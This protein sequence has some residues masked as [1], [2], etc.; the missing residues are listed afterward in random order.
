MRALKLSSCPSNRVSSSDSASAIAVATS[1]R[2]L[3]AQCLEHVTHAGLG[4]T[5]QGD[6]VRQSLARERLEGLGEWS[7]HVEVDIPVGPNDEQRQLGDVLQQQERRVVGPVQVVDQQDLRRHARAPLD[8][9][10]EAVEQVAALLLRRQLDGRWNIREHTPQLRDELRHLGCRFT[11]RVAECR[12]RH[13]ARRAFHHL[14][15]R[16]EWWGA[17]H[18]VTATGQ[19]QT[20]ALARVPEDLLGE[21]RLANARLPADQ[22]Q[23]ATAPHR[24][25]EPLAQLGVLTVAPDER[26]APAPEWWRTGVGDRRHRLGPAGGDVTQPPHLDRHR[27][28]RLIPVVRRFREQLVEDGAVDRVAATLGVTRGITKNRRDRLADG[29]ALERVLAGQQL[30]QHDTE[31]EDVR[32]G[33]CRLTAN[34]LW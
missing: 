23:T 7:R 21:P 5:P 27:L 6:L 26:R 13:D 4:Q 18:L 2:C 17:C 31:R 25:V 3:A 1:W 20:P 24:L 32:S 8:E 19:R 15:P 12:P 33:V 30:E 22:H 28:E 14:D 29:A 34:L 10:A 9:V 16:N 11:E